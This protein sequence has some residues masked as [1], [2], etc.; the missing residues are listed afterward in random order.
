MPA[1]SEHQRVEVLRGQDSNL[2]PDGYEPSELPLLHPAIFWD[3][4]VF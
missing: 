4:I 2:Q 3:Y 1:L